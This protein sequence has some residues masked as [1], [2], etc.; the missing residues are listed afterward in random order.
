V[1]V[2]FLADNTWSPYATFVVAPG[3]TF[4]HVFPEGFHAHWVR[5]LSDTTTTA[6]AR[7]AYGPADHS[8]LRDKE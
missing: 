1:E 7:F 2:D 5:V 6:S 4:T 8:F 3:E